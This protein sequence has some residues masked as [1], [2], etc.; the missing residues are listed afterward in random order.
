VFDRQDG[1]DGYA[2]KKHIF[3][4]MYEQID[5]KLNLTSE[6][7]SYLTDRINC[8]IKEYKAKAKSKKRG[9]HIYQ[10]IAIIAAA[11]VPVFSGF[12]TGQAMLLKLL[13]ALLGGTSAVTAGLLSLFKFQE[14]WI[15]YRCAY[16]DLE[17]HIEQFK[18]GAGIYRD[19]KNA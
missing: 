11:L 12:V 13:V 17:S 7:Q 9:F 2:I 16:E 18:V 3:E 4:R 8:K 10:I 5:E 1:G 19:K 15:K 14:N 6:Q